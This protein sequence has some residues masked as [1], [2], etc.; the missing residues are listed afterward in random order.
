M[1]NATI[2]AKQLANISMYQTLWG[3]KEAQFI[4]WH[5]CAPLVVKLLRYFRGDVNIKRYGCSRA[6]FLSACANMLRAHEEYFTW[7]VVKLLLWEFLGLG[8]G[9]CIHYNHQRWPPAAPPHLVRR[10]LCCYR[11]PATDHYTNSAAA[12]ASAQVVAAAAALW[13]SGLRL[14]QGS[15]TS[16]S[17]TTSSIGAT[18]ISLCQ[19]LL[20]LFCRRQLRHAA[21]TTMTTCGGAAVAAVAAAAK[22]YCCAECRQLLPLPNCRPLSCAAAAAVIAWAGHG[23]SDPNYPFRRGLERSHLRTGR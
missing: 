22:W 2:G 10:C 15:S 3:D 19:Q 9:T 16:H 20:P 5:I 7:D 18:T 21:T 14:W 13:C 6:F 8:P 1:Q 12:A 23:D 4:S 11:C 17:G